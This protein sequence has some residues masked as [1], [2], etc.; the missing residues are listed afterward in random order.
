MAWGQ[1]CSSWDDSVD[2]A[3]LEAFG[4][5]QTPND[6]FV[7]TTWHPDEPLEEVFSY[8][9]YSAQHPML[10]LKNLVIVHITQ[11]GHQDFKDVYES[12]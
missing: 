9:K 8:A 7:M 1:D 4:F 12:A 2:M 3:S 5:Q 10:E 6:K 11:S